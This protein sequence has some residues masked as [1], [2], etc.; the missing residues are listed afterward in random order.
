MPIA[1]LARLYAVVLALAACGDDD[2]SFP[3]AG[4]GDGATGD[5]GGD[6]CASRATC[7]AAG[8]SCVG[9]EL[10]TCAEDADGCLVE[11]RTDCGA[12]GEVCDDTAAPACVDACALIP[13]ADRCDTDGARSCN[14]DTLEVCG[15]D[16]DGCLVLERTDCGASSG[17]ACDPDGA[18]PACVLPPDPCESI[19]AAE[20]CDTAGTSCTGDTL[21]TCAPNAFGCLVSTETDCTAR[22]GGTCD[23][24]ASPPAC[25]FTGDPCAGVTECASAGATCDGP[26]LVVC[27]ADGFGCLLETRTDCTATMFGFC[28]D[29]ATPAPLCSTAATDPCMGVT[30]CGEAITRTCTAAATLEVCAPNA[31]G[32]FVTTTTDCSAT[33]EVCDDG[34]GTAMCVDACSLVTTCPAA[35]WCD[36]DDLVTCTADG[37][38]CLVESGRTACT[39]TCDP[40]PATPVC[41]DTGCPE[42]VAGFLDCSSGTV[43]GDTAMGSMA[44]TGAYGTCYS[45]TNYAGAEQHWRFRHT[46]TERMA[47][48]VTSTSTTSRDFD[49][50]VLDGGD[51][52]ATCASG[53]L[54][55]LDSGRTSDADETVEFVGE[56]GETEFVVFDLYSTPTTDTAAY[57]LTVTCT[58]I[59]CGDGT[60]SLGESCEDGNTT[61]GDG[62]SATCTVETGY[63][64]FGT[65]AGSCIAEASNA[66]CAS[67][68]T[69]TADTTLTGEDLA[70]GG[71]RPSGSGCGGGSGSYA[72][73]Y[74]VT[75]PAN[76]NVLVQ[77]TPSSDI[78]LF[79]Q[80]ACS[81]TGCTSST[82]SSPERTTLTNTGT[83][84]ITRIVGVRPYSTA[85]GTYDI[86]FTYA[87]LPYT[88]ASITGACVTTG[89]WTSLTRS[90][91]GNDATTP[92]TALPFTITYFGEAMTHYSTNTNGIAQLWPSSS[93]TPSGAWSNVAMP[94]TSTPN[95]VVAPFWDDLYLGSSFDI[96]TQTVGSS[97]SQVFVIEWLDALP[98]SSG[99]SV[100]F[101][102]HLYETTNVIEFHYC[103]V[104]TG[105]RESGD[106]AT[107]GI[108][109]STGSSG[110]TISHNSAG[111]VATGTAYRLT[112]L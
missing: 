35:T 88:V 68:T 55:C 57:D 84:A 71:D 104:S 41:I 65:G 47:V 95:S 14:G 27:E 7:A 20:R 36:G 59:V 24:S 106:S 52:S 12:S 77:T 48:T 37:D 66:T 72:L 63:N 10:V 102:A 93:G 29:A 6:P 43:S 70:E 110:V 45:G 79:T 69:I 53:T 64:C 40:A 33:S 42:A 56:P 11:T 85:T 103:D 100:T 50:F 49:L 4:A 76:T 13:E 38:G 16:A 62:C 73:Y 23:A 54:A 3:D 75:I 82:D 58:P 105:S 96:R 25:A 78:V 46:G 22:A 26:E 1:R 97:G 15:M 99:S 44:N 107:I 2:R 112:P 101:Q 92:I 60:I 109:S 74:S 5:G 98:G 87:A 28:D 9:D 30:E 83:T 94:S 108:E 31:F 90:S 39:D 8:A 80:D 111:A 34:T 32:C 86:S 17:G 89:T 91:T 18:M 67:A 21:V 81:D 51:G 19:P 61:D